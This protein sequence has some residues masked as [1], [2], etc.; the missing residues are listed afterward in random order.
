MANLWSSSDSE[1]GD[2]TPFK[3]KAQ[4]SNVF[5]D[6]EKEYPTTDY[7]AGAE[8]LITPREVMSELSFQPLKIFNSMGYTLPIGDWITDK[9]TLDILFIDKHGQEKP[10][11]ALPHLTTPFH[12]FEWKVREWSGTNLSSL[13][14]NEISPTY[15]F[16]TEK[17]DFNRLVQRVNTLIRTGRL[18]V[19]SNYETCPIVA[20][21]DTLATIMRTPANKERW[22]VYSWKLNGVIFLKR[23]RGPL[24]NQSTKRSLKQIDAT[25]ISLNF[26]RLMTQSIEERYQTLNEAEKHMK[27]KSLLFKN[28]HTLVTIS[29]VNAVG[30]GY[31]RFGIGD[32]RINE[33]DCLL[34]LETS[35][36]KVLVHKE[37]FFHEN[38]LKYFTLT[39]VSGKDR[40]I[41]G[42]KNHY[43][44]QWKLEDVEVI[45]SSQPVSFATKMTH[46]QGKEKWDPKIYLDFLDRFLDFLKDIMQKTKTKEGS[47]TIL[48]F[49]PDFQELI[50]K[51]M[52]YNYQHLPEN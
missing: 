2:D 5:L 32:D 16:A 4:E 21:D 42:L 47:V 33:I 41:L 6:T 51:F 13:C 30:K 17:S 23:R 29:E 25:N 38:L 50:P 8:R 31:S 44:N 28:K 46:Y 11:P 35:K 36:L 1:S 49:Q 40:L 27:I 34:T 43:R 15:G 20:T 12:D 3:M 19:D 24:A 22:E 9:R 26:R 52:K 48:T 18:S 37:Q 14:Q 45:D 39:Q 10:G 7:D